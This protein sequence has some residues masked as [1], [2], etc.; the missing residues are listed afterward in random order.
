VTAERYYPGGFG[1][2]GFLK[3]DEMPV[4]AIYHQTKSEAGF[5][6]HRDRIAR[7]LAVLTLYTALGCLVAA[8]VLAAGFMEF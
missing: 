1:R 3:E 2:R 7:R 4:C 6:W 8:V 5:P